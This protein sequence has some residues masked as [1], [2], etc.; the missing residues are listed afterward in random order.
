MQ[1]VIVPW[2]NFFF[3]Y[4][5]TIPWNNHYDHVRIINHSRGQHVSLH[6]MWG[7]L[8][9]QV[10]R[11]F[12][13]N[14]YLDFVALILIILL[15]FDLDLT[16]WSPPRPLCMCDY[17]WM[18]KRSL[19]RRFRFP[20]QPL[21]KWLS[22]EWF[23]YY[24][25]FCSSCSVAAMFLLFCCCCCSFSVV[26]ILLLL[27]F[28]FCCFCF[29]SFVIIVV[30]LLGMLPLLLYIYMYIYTCICTFSIFLF[31]WSILLPTYQHL[32]IK[33]YDTRTSHVVANL[34][35]IKVSG[36]CWNWKPTPG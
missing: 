28:Y 14:K 22:C 29:S 26:V 36:N 32:Q 10:C 21:R 35:G 7:L 34:G 3:M 9:H 33:I 13:L 15:W 23:W 12:F 31:L 1:L 4:Y 20:R 27:L 25:Y 5:L 30:L 16:V 24:M 17:L 2:I 19:P 11:I 8:S 18:A 6:R